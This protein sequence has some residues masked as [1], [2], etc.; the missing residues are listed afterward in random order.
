[1]H[2]AQD[3]GG[4]SARRDLFV[5]AGATIVIA[6][7]SVHFDL[8]EA[9]Q[10][11]SR[12]WERYQLDEFPGVL[13][14]AAVALTW[15]IWRRIREARAELERRVTV[16]RELATVLA[17]NRRLSHS[18]VRLQ[19]DERRRVARELHDEL[20][21]HLNA[22][23]IDA[24]AIREAAAGK[25]PEAHSAAIGII[26]VADHLHVLI[27]D[28]VRSLRPAGL[29]EL[30]L[31]AALEHYVEAWRARSGQV[32]VD[33]HLGGDVEALGEVLNITIYRLIQESLTNISRHAH[34]RNVEIYVECE[35]DREG[36]H[37]AVTVADD[38]KG[39]PHVWSSDGLGLIGLRERV[40]ALGGRMALLS[41]AGRGFRLSATLPIGGVPL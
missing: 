9:L 27:R 34:A 19:E 22:I 17:E 30:G 13:L 14:F 20:G 31:P 40:E 16:E 33:L 38:G 7:A 1:M 24:V 5:G 10:A 3:H 2:P 12:R 29:D 6:I 37:V 8:S 11:W 25:L 15:F 39:C 36:S 18:Q 23:K 4:A 28:M 41:E 35:D 32:A 26:G 21:Q